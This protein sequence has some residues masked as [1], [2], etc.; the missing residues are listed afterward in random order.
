MSALVGLILVLLGGAALGAGVIYARTNLILL[1]EANHLLPYVDYAVFAVVGAT[2]LF[3]I[4]TFIVCAVSSGWNAKR[5]FEGSKKAGCGRCLN[6]T[7]S[8][9]TQTGAAHW[10]LPVFNWHLRVYANS[11]QTHT[12][13]ICLIL[14]IILWTLL[15]ALLA[16]PITSMSLLLYRD[17]GPTRVNSRTR[18]GTEVVARPLRTARQ[19]SAESGGPDFQPRIPPYGRPMSPI[20]PIGMPP[21]ED[22]LRKLDRSLSPIPNPHDLISQYFQCSALSVDLS[23]YGLYDDKGYPLTITSMNL[24][25]RIRNTMIFS[26]L[27]FVGNLFVLFGYLLMLVCVAMNCSKLQ[28][29][30][31]YD[32]SESGD[33]VIRLNQ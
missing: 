4:I 20:K 21:S 1:T 26:S 6:T 10:C 5:F 8:S 28:E 11:P 16:Y 23:Y 12:L 18:M 9:L 22:H 30:R 15:A 25:L 33:D 17:M 29:A 2:G 19:A 31:Y 3:A 27:S 32:P 14:G 24:N 13:L 7:V